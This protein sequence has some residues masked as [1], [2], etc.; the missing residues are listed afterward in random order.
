MLTSAQKREMNGVQLGLLTCSPG[1]EIYSL[2]G[3][4][5]IHYR[6]PERGI[7]VAINY[8]LFNYHRPHFIVRF[9]FGLCDYEMGVIPFDSFLSEY[10]EEGRG[11][12][13]QRV[14]MSP[15]EKWNVIRAL[16]INAEDANRVY[17]YN[18]F[19]DNCSSRARDMLVNHIFGK[20]VYKHNP[21][22]VSSYRTMIHQWNYKNPW[23]SFGCDLLLGVGADRSTCLAQ[24]QFLPD[25]LRASFA[26]AEV[27]RPGSH[28]QP[29]VDST[30][31]VLQ[32]P[33]AEASHG[34]ASWLTPQVVFAILA[35]L[36]F[37]VA[38]YE[39]KRKHTLWGIDAV[40]LLIDGL[41]GIVLFLMIFSK[42]PTVSLNFQLFALNPLSLVLCFL[43][44]RR[45]QDN[46]VKLWWQILTIC[47][48]L[49]FVC[50]IWQVYAKGMNF[51]A[52]CLMGRCI[53]NIYSL[54]YN[55]T[56]R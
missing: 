53:V 23:S 55:K 6:N 43:V 46:T 24:Q 35:V 42:H 49:F 32:C 38:C 11:V 2:Y 19:Y 33:K 13:E 56:T 1:K 37:A 10:V 9:V 34:F 12:I 4:T 45:K 52:L 36:L 29:L 15:E 28:P 18:F 8:G 44:V 25:S 30:W 22:I 48:L 41:A 27:L 16:A 5:A 51:L 21:Q 50:N 40:L 26:K 31:T 20:V 17:R 7:D 39:V 3:H 54:K 14:R 47:L